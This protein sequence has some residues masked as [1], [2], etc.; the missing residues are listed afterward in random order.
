M[1]QNVYRENLY[2][3]ADHDRGAMDTEAKKRPT[4]EETALRLAMGHS[5]AK[6][7]HDGLGGAFNEQTQQEIRRP[8]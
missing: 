2:P 1:H 8:K 4:N 7:A 3:A 5:M 6:I